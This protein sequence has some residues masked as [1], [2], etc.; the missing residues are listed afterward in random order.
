MTSDTSRDDSRKPLALSAPFAIALG[1][2]PA[3]AVTGTLQAGL[4]MGLAVGA[5]LVGASV[6]VSLLRPL[7]PQRLRAAGLLVVI[8]GLAAL[9]EIAMQAAAPAMARSLGIY[10]P[11]I[12]VS[13]LIFSRASE[14]AAARG[15]LAS[16]QGGLRV[17]LGYL[18]SLVLISAIREIFGAATLWGY[19]VAPITL[20]DRA[21]LPEFTPATIFALAPGAFLVVGLLA[22]LFT[23]LRQRPIL[24]AS[25]RATSASSPTLAPAASTPPS[26][27]TRDLTLAARVPAPG[28]AC[29]QAV[30]PSMDA[31]AA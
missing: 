1:L 11:L 22:G 3:L 14:F 20:G 2:T 28:S 19:P 29:K 7:L 25:S 27:I 31:G 23:W 10:V 6:A 13:T 8:A 5:V 9:A 30:A 26:G 17:G 15:P 18:G 4:A 21:L 12:A 24:Q 16:L